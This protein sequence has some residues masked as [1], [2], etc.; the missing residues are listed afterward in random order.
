MNRIMYSHLAVTTM[1]GTAHH[2]LKQPKYIKDRNASWKSVFEWYDKDAIKMRLRS[3][4]GQNE[5]ATVARLHQMT[6]IT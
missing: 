1:G 2:L 3:A 6:Q 4:L 5:R